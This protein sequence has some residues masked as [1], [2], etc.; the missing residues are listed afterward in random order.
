MDELGNVWSALGQ[1]M[2]AYQLDLYTVWRNPNSPFEIH[3]TDYEAAYLAMDFT[4]WALLAL[5]C[6]RGAGDDLARREHG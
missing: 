3:F 5:G 1:M 2:H 4:D 6:W